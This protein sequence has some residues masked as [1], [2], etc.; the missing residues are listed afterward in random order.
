MTLQTIA[1]KLLAA[2][3][4]GIW[5]CAIFGM[6]LAP[7]PVSAQTAGPYYTVELTKDARE[8]R[9][10]ASGVVWHCEGTRCLAAKGTSRP[11]RVCRQLQRKVGEIAAMTS[12]GAIMQATDLARCNS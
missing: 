2:G 12:D 10:V 5:T 4:A 3:I 8:T 9:V 6:A 11:L 7:S 1:R